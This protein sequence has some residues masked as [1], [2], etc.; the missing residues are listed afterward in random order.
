MTETTGIRT[1]LSSPFARVDH[2][3]HGRPDMDRETI[4]IGLRSCRAR[5][6]MSS[7]GL[8]LGRPSLQNREEV[9]AHAEH[10]IEASERGRRI[11]RRRTDRFA[12]HGVED[13]R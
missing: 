13:D 10:V 11:H 8:T 9:D 3:E 7:L 4:P 1:R 2:D 5:C 12:E 6:S